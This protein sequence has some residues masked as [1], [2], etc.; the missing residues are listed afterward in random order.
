MKIE[1]GVPLPQPRGAANGVTKVMRQ[2]EI[3]DSI[4]IPLVSR[5]NVR[6]YGLRL[7]IHFVTRKISETE[8]RVWRVK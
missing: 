5:A 7:G 3:G 8:V 2:M 6:N 4:I 1:K